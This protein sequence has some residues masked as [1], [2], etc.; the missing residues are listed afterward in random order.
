MFSYDST[1]A[2]DVR[3]EAARPGAAHVVHDLTYA[4]P[5]GGRVP[6]YLVVPD[7]PGPFPAIIY[8][9]PGQGDRST[10][11]PEA[12]ALATA[13]VAS[14]LI[15][16]P[17]R[18]P[19][20]TRPAAGTPLQ[21]IATTEARAYRQLVVDVRRGIDL[22]AVTPGS[23]PERIGY[24]GHSLGATWGGPL[25]GVE[26][27][28]RALVL[29]AGFPSLTAAYR[30]NPHPAL[31]GMR[32]RL[33]PDDLDCYLEIL[34]PLDAVHYIGQ[35]APA[36]LLFQFARRDEFIT[37]EEAELYFR[38]AS[39]PKEITWYDADHF[40]SGVPAARRDRVDWLAS[41]LAFEPPGNETLGLD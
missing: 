21:A 26:T 27:R 6:A 13:G 14:L 23:D 35:A 36:A 17:F 3:E 8:V 15:D 24:V 30:S 33:S 39:E 12:Q 20:F 19:D 16:A 28:L 1:Q 22:L 25:A 37:P 4:S 29:M 38:L 9:H 31:S 18:R 10:Y 2:L 7:G 34:A 40:F 41:R 5:L 11:L 32:S